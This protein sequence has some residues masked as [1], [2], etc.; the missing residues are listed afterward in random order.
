M[1]G[2]GPRRNSSRTIA[3]LADKDEALAQEFKKLE[4]NYAQ[5]SYYQG[6]LEYE[7]EALK[8][9]LMSEVGFRV[10]VLV[11]VLVHMS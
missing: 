1:A 8:A 3:E 5:S 7:P 2:L 6:L 11:L 9:L 4:A 10:V